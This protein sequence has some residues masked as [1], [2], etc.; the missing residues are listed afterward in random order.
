MTR[1]FSAA[2][3]LHAEGI[4]RKSLS[5]KFRIIEQLITDQ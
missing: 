4:Q 1:H 2:N 5:V 3:K